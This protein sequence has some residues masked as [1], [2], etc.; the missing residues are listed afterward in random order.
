MDIEKI[1]EYYKQTQ[2]EY[3]VMWNWNVK[4]IP[5]LHFGFYDEKATN[6]K[7][8]LTR[9]NEAL[10]EWAEIKHGSRIIDAGCGL[11]QSAAWLAQYY[12]ATVTGITLA[13]NQVEGATKRIQKTGISNVDF[14]EAN[15]LQMPFEDNSVDVVWAFESVCYATDKHAFYQEAF[16][17]LKPGGKLVM[18]EY[19]RT[20]RPLSAPNE[21][22]L[23][24]VF[25]GWMVVDL[26]TIE[27]HEQHSVTSGFTGFRF[28]DVTNNV[29]PSYKNLN[30]LGKRFTWLA[31][32]LRNTGIISGLRYQNMRDSMKQLDCIEN[33]VFFYAHLTATKA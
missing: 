12:D 18:A 3:R 5:A 33:D 22:L 23:K 25:S 2:F 10:A 27:E 7:Q 15:Y 26:D 9:A 1:K 13:P 14:K 17:V 21:Q 32:L 24:E 29:L 11:G 8:A 6:Y 30:Q 16:R 4:N 31:W 28:R 20:T 19:I